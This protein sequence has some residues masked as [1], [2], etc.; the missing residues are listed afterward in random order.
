MLVGPVWPRGQKKEKISIIIKCKNTNLLTILV[1]IHVIIHLSRFFTEIQ[2]SIIIVVNILDRQPVL[3]L[4]LMLDGK[5]V[6]SSITFN[7]N[8]IKLKGRTCLLRVLGVRSS[9]Y[10]IGIYYVLFP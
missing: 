8:L 3:R 6:I 9:R 10:I 2:Y 7:N 4:V 1:I 5:S